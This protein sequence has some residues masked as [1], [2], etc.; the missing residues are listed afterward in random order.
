MANDDGLRTLRRPEPNLGRGGVFLLLYPDPK[1]LPEI[2]FSWREDI[3][4]SSRVII[5]V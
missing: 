3:R 5:P 2:S 1:L 4:K